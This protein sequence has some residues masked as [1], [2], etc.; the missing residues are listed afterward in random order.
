VAIA[1]RAS[2]AGGW[3]TGD[4]N[5]TL[6]KPTGTAEGDILVAFICGDSDTTITPPTGFSLVWTESAT[7]F[8][9]S[10]GLCY[11]K[12]AGA[13]E[14]SSYTWTF[15]PTDMWFVG[16]VSAYSGCVDSGSPID[17]YRTLGL[18]SQINPTHTISGITTTEDGCMLVMHT[19][20][21]SDQDNWGSWSSPL[22]GRSGSTGSGEGSGVQNDAGASGDKSATRDWGGTASIIMGLLA[23]LPYAEASGDDLTASSMATGAPVLQAATIAHG[24]ILSARIEGQG[25]RLDWVEA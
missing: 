23:L 3:F 6:S 16:L 15:S 13:S 11:W 9:A 18:D 1:Y 19:Y 22:V 21:S 25:I 17:V 14:P 7:T 5:I 8:W 20:S 12:R 4:G 2:T 10:T 24:P